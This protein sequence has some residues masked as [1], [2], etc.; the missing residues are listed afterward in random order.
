MKNIK[1]L[2]NEY[3]IYEDGNVEKTN[4][5]KIKFYILNGYKTFSHKGKIHYVHKLV[6]E[7][8][9]I[10]I[11]NYKI[12]NHIDGNKLN[13]NVNNLEWCSYSHN[14]KE[15]Y[16]LNLRNKKTCNSNHKQ[17]IMLD[18]NKKEICIFRMIKN[19]EALF[20]KNCSGNII[21]AIKTNGVTFGYYWKYND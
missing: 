8:F 10:N 3:I 11:D 20:G 4:G 5:G 14:L 12:T 1:I 19:T 6:A 2:S 15:A 17:I 21:R 18:S 7:N 9:I 13:N 16:R